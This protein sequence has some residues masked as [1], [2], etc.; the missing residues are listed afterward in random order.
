MHGSSGVA[1]KSPH[2]TICTVLMF[3][4]CATQNAFNLEHISF[5]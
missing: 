4:H 2:T 1:L 5:A 3:E